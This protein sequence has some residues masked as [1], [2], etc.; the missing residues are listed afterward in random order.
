MNW[1]YWWSAQ[2]LEGRGAWDPAF[3]T[4]FETWKGWG[5]EGWDLCSFQTVPFNGPHFTEGV[6]VVAIFRR[7]AG[8][9]APG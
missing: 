1:D 8:Y 6:W 7:P 3:A 5:R 2:Y 9:V 4:W